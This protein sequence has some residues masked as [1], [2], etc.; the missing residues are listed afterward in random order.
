MAGKVGSV[1]QNYFSSWLSEGKITRAIIYKSDLISMLN[2][3]FGLILLSFAAR[4]IKIVSTFLI[5]VLRVEH[6]LWKLK[7][8][9]EN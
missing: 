6:L 1:Y 8:R 9:E 2:A 3:D 5:F 7:V 4:V